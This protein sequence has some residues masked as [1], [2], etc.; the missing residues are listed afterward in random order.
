MATKVSLQESHLY[1]LILV[2]RLF[3]PIE[4][5][6][7][8]FGIAVGGVHSQQVKYKHNARFLKSDW[9]CAFHKRVCLQITSTD[10]GVRFLIQI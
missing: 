3:R 10:M 7:T 4:I 2:H 5:H 9:A 8:K 1:I 6:Q